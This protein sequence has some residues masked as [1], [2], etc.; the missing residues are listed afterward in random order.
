M[1]NNLIHKT[2]YIYPNTII[3][4]NVKIGPNCSIG[5]EGFE[6]TR[7]EDHLPQFVEHMGIVVIEHDVEIQANT[8]IA[9]GLNENDRTVIGAH[10]KIEDLVHI[11]H[12]CRVGRGNVITAGTIFGGSVRVGN[13]NFFGINCSI[14]PGIVIGDYNLIGMGSVVL[15]DMLNNE[16]WGGNP[17]RKLKDNLYWLGVNVI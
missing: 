7:D 11:A 13:C 1:D 6:F 12:N 16:I 4:S 15:T 14:Y 3:G 17:A 9:R 8:V 2:A 10:T 5:Y